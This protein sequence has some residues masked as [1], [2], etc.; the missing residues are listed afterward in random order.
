MSTRFIFIDDNY[1]SCYIAEKL[2]KTLGIAE[3]V[4]SFL[5]AEIALSYI[6]TDHTNIEKAVIM[7]DLQMPQMNGFKFIE[8]FEQLPPEVREKFDLYILTSS[9][10]EKDLIHASV[11]PSVK[12]FFSKPLT[13]AIVHQVMS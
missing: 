3:N 8:A 7:L 1:L 11:Y 2:V 13:A 6:E 4:V 10:N 12:K 9:I 5:Q